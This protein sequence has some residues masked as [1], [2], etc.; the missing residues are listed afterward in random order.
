MVLL[1]ISILIIFSMYLDFDVI[2]DDTCPNSANGSALAQR[3]KGLEIESHTPDFFS[4]AYGIF[5]SR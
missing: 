5:S 2:N 4:S 3:G 1:V